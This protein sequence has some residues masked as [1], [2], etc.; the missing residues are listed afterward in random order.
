MKPGLVF[1]LIIISISGVYAMGEEI[2]L[3][4]LLLAAVVSG[5]RRRF[6][7]GRK[8]FCP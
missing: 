5:A 8:V 7:S 4:L 2:R 3:K 1:V 6:L